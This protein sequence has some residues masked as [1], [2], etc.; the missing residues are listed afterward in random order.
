MPV[1]IEPEL[2]AIASRPCPRSIRENAPVLAQEARRVA[3]VGCGFMKGTEEL[4]KHH[5]RVYAVDTE[6]QRD[7]ID[8]RIV[9]LSGNP[10]FGGFKSFDEFAQSSLRLGG[11]YV[12]NVLHT[13][14][15]PRR[16]VSLLQVV[17]KNLR[18]DGFVLIDVPYYEHYY[19]EKMTPENAHGDGYVFPQGGERFTFYRFSSREDIDA[20]ARAA[21][22]T[23]E[24]E[25]T[26]NHHFVHVY[27]LT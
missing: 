24:S 2:S 16:R 15:S 1:H 21:G 19:T 10:R 13:L 27:R 12:V 18:R 17:R 9:K 26:D 14:P 3:D 22:L 4:L 8:K 25:W 5:E 20:W 11:A 23:R 7:R 6:L